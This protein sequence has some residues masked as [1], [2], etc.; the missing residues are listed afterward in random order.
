MHF[1]LS[2]VTKLAMWT[3]V[4]VF[5]F[6][7]DVCFPQAIP[8]IL[9]K[10][11]NSEELQTYYRE[12]SVEIRLTAKNKRT[13]VSKDIFGTGFLASSDGIVITA[14]HVIEPAV[15]P[16]YEL[17]KAV[18][19]RLHDGYR[20]IQLDGVPNSYQLSMRA[21]IGL[22][23]VSSDARPTFKYMCID[24]DDPKLDLSEKVTMASFRYLGN[25]FFRVDQTF[26]E[27]V[28]ITHSAG[29]GDM[30]RYLGLAQPI[31]ESMSGGA[32]I[33]ERS[34]RVIAVM[35]NVLVRD[36]LPIPGENYA[37]LL[38]SATDIGLNSIEKCHPAIPDE[39]DLQRAQSQ[40]QFMVASCEGTLAWIPDG[41]Q[42]E[43]WFF[44]ERGNYSLRR[45]DLPACRNGREMSKVV[46]MVLNHNVR[47][48]CHRERPACSFPISTQTFY[49]VQVVPKIKEGD[50]GSTDQQ[51]WLYKNKILYARSQKGDFFTP[52]D[53]KPRDPDIL[54]ATPPSK[55]NEATRFA[56]PAQQVNICGSKVGKEGC[57][58]IVAIKSFEK[59][60]G[61]K[62]P[63][64]GFPRRDNGVQSTLSV[65]PKTLWL[66]RDDWLDDGKDLQVK[67]WILLYR[68]TD[69]A[70]T[71][72]PIEFSF[73]VDQE[74]EEFYIRAFSPERC[75]IAE[76]IHVFLL[77]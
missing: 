58:D 8:A 23:K 28:S 40:K 64:H 34:D 10:A 32:V 30:F 51:T 41:P 14:R 56:E 59:D 33:R 21:D 55:F 77:D 35:S 16:D 38:Q 3:T 7:A 31:E 67:N 52:T 5:L 24:S 42:G 57:K 76:S 12:R 15:S 70:G 71:K 13:N 26:T 4:P 37:N 36:G 2:R 27:H 65:S 11:S 74:W 75:V 73:C 45:K 20:I 18:E 6:R 60:L 69:Q 44:R 49:G 29:P 62:R 17:E 9:H 25:P 68:G 66:V 53:R 47:G 50:E 19:V 63:W 1:T 54:D 22:F 48:N 43:H 46:R 39:K 72:E 61:S